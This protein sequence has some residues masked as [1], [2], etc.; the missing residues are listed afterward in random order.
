MMSAGPIFT[1][2]CDESRSPVALAPAARLLIGYGNDLRSDDG[3]GIRAAQMIAAR[4][5]PVRVITCHQ[6]TPEL[7]DDIAAV[8]QVVFVDAYAASE[9]GAR[10]RIER[11]GDGDGEARG[12][13][14]H[15]CDP[16]ALLDLARRL[17]GRVPDA[18]VIGIPAYC[19]D[20]GEAISR[21][22]AQRVDE[23]VAWF[24]K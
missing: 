18:W 9:R 8:A 11:I 23:V 1:A 14:V 2:R 19:F 24:G 12:A 3:A 15:R 20:A 13:P 4:D 21:A 17:H 10:L 16:A 5:L 6:L 7:V 22:T